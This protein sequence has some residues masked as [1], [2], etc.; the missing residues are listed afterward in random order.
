MN[1]RS[2]DG[3]HWSAWISLPSWLVGSF[4]LASFA[5]DI[6]AA[7][8][9]S[10]SSLPLDHAERMVRGLD[11]FQKNVR[12]LLTEHCLKCHGGEKTKGEFDL[13]TRDGLLKGGADGV[14]VTLFNSKSSR[15]CEL[16]NHASE[17]HMPS[18]GLKLPDESIRQI[19]LWID[20]GAPY[21]RPLVEGKPTA[22]KDRSRVT[23]SDR[24]WW[25]FRALK[26]VQPP[27][28]A[29]SQ[30]TSSAVDRFILARLNEK[31]STLNSRAKRC[32]FRR[33]AKT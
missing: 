30:P 24:Q 1:I 4:F 14:A 2:S 17:P 33:A 11:L 32:K 23:T 20:N 27:D 25:A 15:L 28:I 22:K 31:Q 5:S 21:D 29:A 6:Y 18:K 26:R 8:N 9:A 13:S 10:P 3:F 7:E 19:A 12:G 16:V